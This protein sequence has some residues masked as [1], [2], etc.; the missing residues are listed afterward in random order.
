MEIDSGIKLHNNYHSGNMGFVELS[1]GICEILLQ[2]VDG[3]NK[4]S[5]GCFVIRFDIFGSTN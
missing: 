3:G 1:R 2:N 5:F 4:I